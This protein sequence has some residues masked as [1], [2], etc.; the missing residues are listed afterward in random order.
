MIEPLALGSD[1][2]SK[3]E[4]NTCTQSRTKA[5]RPPMCAFV[6]SSEPHSN[7]LNMLLDS[8]WIGSGEKPIVLKGIETILEICSDGINR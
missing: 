7:P 2:T 4:V 1:D 6:Q 3:I 5:T 8:L